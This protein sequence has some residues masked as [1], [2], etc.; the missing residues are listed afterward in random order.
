MYTDVHKNH[1]NRGN[2]IKM[3]DGEGYIYEMLLWPKVWDIS[4]KQSTSYCAC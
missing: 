3:N 4:R 1:W 2:L